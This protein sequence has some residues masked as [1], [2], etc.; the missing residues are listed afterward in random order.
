MLRRQYGSSRKMLDFVV[1]LL[2][3]ASLNPVLAC[4]H[5]LGIPYPHLYRGTAH[6]MDR[7]REGAQGTT[8]EIHQVTVPGSELAIVSR[9]E[10]Q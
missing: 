5:S 9:V 10:K 3:S 1:G 4:L 2:P 6:E 7:D 8:P